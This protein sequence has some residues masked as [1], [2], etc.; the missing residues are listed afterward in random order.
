MCCVMFIYRHS[1]QPGHV[2]NRYMNEILKG[3]MNFTGF[4]LSGWQ[5]VINLYERDKVVESPEET[6]RMAVL[7]DMNE[8][9][10]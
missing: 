4:T 7:S 2:N 10:I 8:K 3:E 1:R 6:V 9:I 5:E